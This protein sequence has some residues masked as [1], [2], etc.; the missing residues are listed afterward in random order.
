MLISISIY[1]FIALLCLFY[2][3]MTLK[4]SCLKFFSDKIHKFNTSLLINRMSDS[5]HFPPPLTPPNFSSFTSVSLMR[6][7][8]SSQSHDTNCVL[9]PIPTSL[10]KQLSHVLLPSITNIIYLMSFSTGIF[11]DNSKTV[12]YILTSK[13]LTKIK[14]ISVIIVLYL[15]SHSCQNSLKE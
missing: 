13:N 9:D 5:P 3:L 4:V 2:H 12:L 6:F 14:M 1:F 8:N 11:S 7:L 10:L 15:T